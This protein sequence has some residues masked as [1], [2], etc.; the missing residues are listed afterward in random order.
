[1]G[2]VRTKGLQTMGA[3]V[4]MQGLQKPIVVHMDSSAVKSFASWRG[5]SPCLQ[6]QA[7]SLRV[8]VQKVLGQENPPDNLGGAFP[9][10]RTT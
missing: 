2:V 4:D 3:E 9:N 6:G 7:L 5:Q 8:V 1:M 10:G